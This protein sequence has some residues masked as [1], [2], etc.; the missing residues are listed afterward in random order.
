MT[1]ECEILGAFLDIK[2][3]AFN[4]PPEDYDRK[5]ETQRNWRGLIKNGGACGLI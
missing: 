2:A 4:I 1:Y 5:I 3:N